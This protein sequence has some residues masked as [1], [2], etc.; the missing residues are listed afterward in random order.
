MNTLSIS[1]LDAVYMTQLCNED[2][3]LL[4]LILL[5]LKANMHVQLN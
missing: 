3:N 4:F 1:I 2:V 5:N